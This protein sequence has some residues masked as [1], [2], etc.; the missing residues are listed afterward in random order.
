MTK[1]AL[2]DPVEDIWYSHHNSWSVTVTPPSQ[3][4]LMGKLSA[5][6]L[7]VVEWLWN[8]GYGVYRGVWSLNLSKFGYC[9]LSR[10]V[11]ALVFWKCMFVS[12]CFE[13]LHSLSIPPP[14]PPLLSSLYPLFEQVISIA[15]FG[16]QIFSLPVD[17]VCWWGFVTLSFS[18]LTWLCPPHPWFWS[19]GDT[20]SYLSQSFR[21]G[22]SCSCP[23]FSHLLCF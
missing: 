5:L 16:G 15:W 21:I 12:K 19:Q 1:H 23:V 10:Q 4:W 22:V 18:V 8:P 7:S 9:L 13:C 17:P 20:M 2:N 6:P 11:L 3:V 14:T